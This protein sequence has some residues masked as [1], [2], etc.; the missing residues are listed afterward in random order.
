MEITHIITKYFKV[1]INSELN[2]I[3]QIEIILKCW[4]HVFVMFSFSIQ[5]SYLMK[6]E[7]ELI[8]YNFMYWY[9]LHYIKTNVVD[10]KT[11]KRGCL[12]I[13]KSSNLKEC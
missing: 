3:Y 9:K 2:F 13:Q 11:K 5:R 6:P 1:N 4:I 12:E 7:F 10:G 8:S